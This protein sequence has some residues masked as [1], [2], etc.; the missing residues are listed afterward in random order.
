[1][2]TKNQIAELVKS[3]ADGRAT[4]DDVDAFNMYTVEEVDEY[5]E[6]LESF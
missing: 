3:L 2:D 5:L 4:F 1:M 6:Y